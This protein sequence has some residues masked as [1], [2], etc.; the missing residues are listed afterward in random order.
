MDPAGYPAPGAGCLA[1]GKCHSGV[2]PIRAHDSEMARQIFDMGSKQ[3]DPNGC[4]VR[5]GGN[6]K[7]EKEAKIAHTGAPGGSRLSE[8][9]VHAGSVWVNEKTC[10]QCH[11]EWTY[12]QALIKQF[13]DNF[14]PSLVQVPAINLDNLKEKPY[15]AIYTYVRTDCQ[16]CHVGVKGRD[17]RGDHRGMGC[18]TCHIPCNNAGL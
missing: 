4:V 3:G 5:H 17:K 18:A 9:V 11:Q 6:P 7:E 15:E 1:P 12:T 2:E 16:R 10:G 13:P 14:P 8:F